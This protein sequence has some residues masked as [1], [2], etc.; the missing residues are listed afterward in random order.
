MAIHRGI[1]VVVTND[2]VRAPYSGV[3][4]S[5]E[6]NDD[7]GNILS[8]S[9]KDDL[10]TVYGHLEKFLV[11]SNDV[12]KAGD[13]IGIVGNTGK[14]VGKHLHLETRLKGELVDPCKGLIIMDADSKANF[15]I[16]KTRSIEK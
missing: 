12:V 2:T 16:Q 6:W 3:V 15:V 11:S 7:Y 13:P 1:D 8:I 10:V 14:S 4:K 9:H 5:A